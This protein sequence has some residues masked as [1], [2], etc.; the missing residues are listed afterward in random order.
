MI[1]LRQYHHQ[2]QHM[3]EK[4]YL[5]FCDESDKR[6]KYF[7]NF[8]GGVIVGASQYQRITGRLNTL[9]NELRLFGETKWEKVTEQYQERYIQLMA[10]FFEEIAAC[11]NSSNSTRLKYRYHDRR[12]RISEWALVRP[13]SPLAVRS[14][15]L[16]IR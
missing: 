3:A 1:Y 9:K 10:A 2:E 16:H 14:R 12:Q 11:R 8:Y 6:G 5:I 15:W 4:E 7:S 13:I